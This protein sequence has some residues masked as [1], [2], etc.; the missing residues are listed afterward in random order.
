MN[1]DE[2]IIENGVDLIHA[3]WLGGCLPSITHICID[4]WSKQGYQ[5]KLWTDAD[6]KIKDWIA[7]CKFAKK[8]YDKGLYAFVTDCLRLKILAEEGGLYLDV[9]VTINNDPFPLFNF[10]FYTNIKS[11]FLKLGDKSN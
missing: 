3:I 5:Y 11:Q 7:H 4:D 8:C 2:L 1:E 10:G 9:D 6:P